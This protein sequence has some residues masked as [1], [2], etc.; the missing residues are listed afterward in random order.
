M[1]KIFILESAKRK[2]PRCNKMVTRRLVRNRVGKDIKKSHLP[3]YPNR[4]GYKC[5][6]F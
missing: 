2:L 3:A 4:R 1:R 5:E 6:F